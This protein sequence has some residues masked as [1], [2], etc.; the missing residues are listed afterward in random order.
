MAIAIVVLAAVACVLVMELPSHAASDVTHYKYWAKQ[1]ATHGV[2]GAYSGTYPETAA[3]YPPVTMYGYRVAGWIYR[4]AFDPAFDMDVALASHALTVLVKLVA[5]VPHLVASVVIFGLLDRRFG[6][7]PALLATAAFALNPAAI[8]DAAYWGQPD[9][10]HAAFLLAAIYLWE[11]DRPLPGYAMIGLAAATKP[12]A[13]AL[14]PFLAYISLRRF[15]LIR[16][17]QGGVVA[18][19]AALAVCLPYIVYGTFGELFTLPRLIA[20]TMPVASANAHNVWWLV[21]NGKPDFVLDADPLIGPVTYRQ[22]AAV[23]SLLVMAFTFWCTNPRARNGELSGMAAYLAFGWFLV[24]TR[25]HENHAFFA[26]PLLVM[27]TPRS[28]FM[29]GMFGLLSLTLF[30]NMAFHDFGLEGLRASLFA[31]ETWLRLQ[32]A[33]AALNIVVFLAW[34]YW[35]L[36]RR[37]RNPLVTAAHSG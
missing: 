23:L 19:V 28:G 32:L 25:A 15:G 9:V 13:W 16:T 4:R 14:F 36:S 8:F 2:A 27:A 30:L 17:V 35:L 20:E 37:A 1:V 24:T 11:E 22:A 33:N 10:I 18:G 21:T 34:S 3:I 5:V 12:Q 29:W 6:A 31:P 26:L 7:R